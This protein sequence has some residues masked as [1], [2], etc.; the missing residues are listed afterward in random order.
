MNK[1]L[2]Q[3]VIFFTLFGFKYEDAI[4]I[5]RSLIV[6]TWFFIWTCLQDICGLLEV[7]YIIQS[8]VEW[9]LEY[10]FQ[11]RNDGNYILN[12]RPWSWLFIK[13]QNI[14]WKRKKSKNENECVCAKRTLKPNTKLIFIKL[15]IWICQKKWI[16][17]FYIMIIQ[18]EH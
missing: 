1:S 17:I 16:R 7:T 15:Y 9:R 11:K 5:S 8:T 18:P 2:V 4:E 12:Q 14:F 10:I 3:A 13:L 6:C